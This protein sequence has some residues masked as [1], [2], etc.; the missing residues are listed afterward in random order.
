MRGDP[1][2]MALGVVILGLDGLPPGLNYVQEALLES[3]YA[4]PDF[5]EVVLR[6]E[7]GEESKALVQR[8]ERVLVT[9][10]LPVHFGEFPRRLGGQKRV[11]FSF[12]HR[13]RSSQRVER[14]LETTRGL[15][16]GS[17]V[18][19]DLSTPAAARAVQRDVASSIARLPGAV[20]VLPDDPHPRQVDVT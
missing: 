8:L 14:Q 19:E 1:L 15:I 6:V 5:R 3:R 16:D 2:T 11:F 18:L 10:L 17:I 13:T 7:V 9:A 12:R 20:V 4:F